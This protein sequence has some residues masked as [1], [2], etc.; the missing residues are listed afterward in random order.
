VP[1]IPDVDATVGE[2]EVLLEQ[3]EAADSQMRARAEEGIRLLMRLYGAGLR[4]AIEILG[5]EAAHQ[6]AQDKLLGSLLLLHGLHPIGAAERIQES[7]EGIE[8]RIGGSRLHLEEISN[9]RARI[10]V[11]RNGSPA[12]PGL[13][14]AIE[15][16]VAES[17]PEIGG[18]EVIGVP[19]PAPALVQIAMQAQTTPEVS[20]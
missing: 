13:A 17:A 19:Q 9:D 14:A 18:V 5:A 12:P 16:A 1:D 20:R 10:R 6:L 11:E 7:L 15:R 3:L 2:I 4:R 8:R